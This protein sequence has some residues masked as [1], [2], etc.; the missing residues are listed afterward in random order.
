VQARYVKIVDPEAMQGTR[1]RP[2]KAAGLG[3]LEWFAM[4]R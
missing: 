2:G 4:P 1:R 3:Q